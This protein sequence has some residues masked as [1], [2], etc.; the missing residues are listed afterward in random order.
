MAACLWEGG[1][2][3][4]NEQNDAEAEAEKGGGVLR[5]ADWGPGC[6]S[7]EEEERTRERRGQN[8]WISGRKKLII[9]MPS[10][11]P[12]PPPSVTNWNFICEWSAL[13]PETLL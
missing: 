9:P 10:P 1:D 8:H 12:S 5:I 4:S 11:S 7:T 2:V 3:R 6:S 13:N